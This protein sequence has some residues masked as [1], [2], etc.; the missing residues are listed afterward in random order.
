MHV[1]PGGVQA[2]VS[3]QVLEPDEVSPTL[4]KMCREAVPQRVGGDLC[5]D[6]GLLRGLS[7]DDLDGPRR[8][9]SPSVGGRQD[10]AGSCGRIGG[11]DLQRLDDLGMQEH[12]P[13]PVA[14]AR[15]DGQDLAFDVQVLPLQL[16]GLGASQSGVVQ[17]H[18]DEL[19]F[20]VPGYSDHAV[21]LVLGQDHRH[22][23]LLLDKRDGGVHLSTQDGGV[24]EG[25]G[26]VGQSYG[27]TAQVGPRQHVLS[28]VLAGAESYL[29]HG[30][31][32]LA[33]AGAVLADA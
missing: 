21:H 7:D 32:C 30:G 27:G 14:L 11:I 16:P 33:G 2:L 4:D 9:R 29:D 15:P 8:Q 17:E 10:E 28:C 6:L 22:P 3:Q 20:E 13:V 26:E 1:D 23:L 24:K 18:D 12:G 25:Q 31:V 5:P 19:V